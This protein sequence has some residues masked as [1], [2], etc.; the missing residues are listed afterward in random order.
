MQSNRHKGLSQPRLLPSSPSVS[1][2]P[3]L[4]SVF[5]ILCFQECYTDVT[6]SLQVNDVG[7]VIFEEENL[8][9]GPGFITQSF[10][11]GKTVLQ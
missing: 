4:V 11:V 6:D 8:S 3:D 9:P 1:S 7:F 10:C 5:L 2:D